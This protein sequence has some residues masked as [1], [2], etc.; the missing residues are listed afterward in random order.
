MV[1]ATSFVLLS[2]GSAAYLSAATLNY[3]NYYPA[4]GQVNSALRVD[5]VSIV[6]GSNFS[7]IDSR[8]SIGNPTDYA[9][10]RLGDA[11]V[12]IFFKVSN[13]NATLFEGV[14]LVQ[15]ETVGG[16]LGPHS[17]V[18]RDI[19]VQLGPES[20]SSFASFNSSYA[21]RVIAAVVLTV[22][23]ITFLNTV[24]G[25]DSYMTTQDVPLSSR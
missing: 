10:F 25:R 23:V 6:P 5:S 9:G 13:S 24:T 15:T 14:H 19:I 7:R 20:V 22:Q 21:G 1:I 16:Q 2:I 17:T 11:I 4:R 18:S 12:S 3:L 8:V